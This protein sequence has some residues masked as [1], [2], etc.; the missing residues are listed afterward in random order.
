MITQIENSIIQ[1]LTLGMGRMLREVASY[2]GELDVDMG[3]IIRAFPAAWV[4]FGGITNSKYTST[5]RQKVIVTGK[6]VVMVGDYNTR[7]DAASRTGGANL[8]EVGTYRHIHGVRRLLTGQ[9]LGLTIDPLM[10]GVVRTLYNTQVNERALSIFACE[11]ETRWH[12]QVLANGAWPEFTSNPDEAD[13]LFN[14]YRGKLQQ[15]DPDL[16]CVGLHYDPPG[17]GS[18]EAPADLVPTRKPTP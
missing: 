18:A 15:P 11:F 5:S 7:S 4:T 12:E 13:N 8:N 16:L 1:R 9:D 10:P 6:F 3:N 2:S 17:V 14:L